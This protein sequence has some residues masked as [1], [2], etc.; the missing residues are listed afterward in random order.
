M[1]HLRHNEIDRQRWDATV[2]ADMTGLP[3]ALS[4]FLDILAPQWEALVSEDYS[5]LFPLPVKK[6]AGMT[7]MLQPPFIQQLGI[8]SDRTVTE[9]E[10]R[11][12]V[13][14]F[15]SGIRYTDIH[16]NERT[17]DA[18]WPGKVFLRRNILIHLEKDTF[19]PESR[20]HEN[21]RRNVRK[22]RD[23]GLSVTRGQENVPEIIRLFATGQGKKYKTIG[24][25]QYR[26]LAR[27]LE[28]CGEEG[29]VEVL[30]VK[31]EDEMLAGVI[32]LQWHRRAVFY[33][34][35]QSDEGRKVQ[36]LTGILD[37]YIRDHAGSGMIL[38]ME[39]SESEGLAR[40]YKGFGGE[41]VFY[42]RLVIN[43]MP[44]PLRWLK[45]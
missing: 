16:L 18:G 1:L 6:K 24:E 40:Y 27:M 10:V 42:P 43:R 19:T 35:A 34:S 4:W 33:F 5:L 45:R 28:R 44:R 12:V 21:T 11:Q 3:Y 41:E 32:F 17:P 30:T 13:Q 23:S 8:F 9:E 37:E 39:G 25:K 20:Y 29:M 31:K 2:A 15:P 36:A 22:F 7:V 26:M 14:A 38:D